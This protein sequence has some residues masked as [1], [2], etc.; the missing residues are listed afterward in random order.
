M[1]Y[2]AMNYPTAFS[3]GLPFAVHTRYSLAVVSLLLAAQ[4]R[5]EVLPREELVGK[6]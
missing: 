3:C 6:E 5:L 2:S 4:G 1:F